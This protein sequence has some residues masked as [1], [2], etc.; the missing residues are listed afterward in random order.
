LRTACPPA[1]APFFGSG[2]DDT[3]CGEVVEWGQAFRKVPDINPF[4]RAVRCYDNM[5]AAAV[6]GCNPPTHIFQPRGYTCM[7]KTADCPVKRDCS[8]LGPDATNTGLYPY[9]VQDDPN[10]LHHVEQAAKM[11]AKSPLCAALQVNTYHRSIEFFSRC[12][13]VYS[14]DDTTP[15]IYEKCTRGTPPNDKMCSADACTL[16][17]PELLPDHQNRYCEGA[18]DMSDAWRCCQ[19]SSGC[20]DTPLWTNN[21][22]DRRLPAG[23]LT[24]NHYRESYCEPFVD[25]IVASL[26]K[27]NGAPFPLDGEENNF[28]ELNCCG[29]GKGAAP[30]PPCS[31]QSELACTVHNYANVSNNYPCVDLKTSGA[32]YPMILSEQGKAKVRE[33]WGADGNPA[34]WSFKTCECV[35]QNAD[36]FVGTWICAQTEPIPQ[37]TCSFLGGPVTI[38]SNYAGEWS[39][40]ISGEDM[41]YC[42]VPPPP[43]PAPTPE[44]T[45]EPTPIPTVMP[46][47]VPSFVPTPEPSAVPTPEP[48]PVPTFEPTPAPTAVPTPVPSPPTPM[49]TPPQPIVAWPAN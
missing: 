39:T 48:T 37:D 16:D 24:C 33:I 46:T 13:R 7:R 43:T 1:P 27:D 42:P 6:T 11:C 47:P 5:A 20:E 3:K 19:R 22:T 14:D 36:G 8:G 17:F 31:E 49:P 26:M 38:D 18:C 15:A 32:H 21:R 9:Y 40:T 45:L 2:E 41:E 23:G 28:P 44:P 30:R 35:S 34:S 25:S 29:C 12:V 10:Q 4:Q